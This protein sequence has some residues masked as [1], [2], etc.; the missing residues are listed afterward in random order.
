MI[1]PLNIFYFIQKH[2]KTTKL[3]FKN[4]KMTYFQIF[5]N[6]SKKSIIDI[7]RRQFFHFFS[8]L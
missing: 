6:V 2:L 8:K 4:V 3:A 5:S 7:D 1:L